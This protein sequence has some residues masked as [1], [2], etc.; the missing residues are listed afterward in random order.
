V[1]QSSR[2]QASKEKKLEKRITQEHTV[3]VRDAE[4]EKKKTYSCQADAKRAL[5]EWQKN[6]KG[7]H[8]F[9]AHIVEESMIPKRP[10]RGRPKKNELKPDPIPVYRNIIQ[11][12]PPSEETL[13]ELRRKESTFI[14][15]TSIRDDARL[16][17]EEVLRAYKEQYQV[18]QRFRFL[19]SPY[20]VGPIYLHN[21]KRVK[22]FGYVM[23]MAV[24][25]YSVLERLIRKAMEKETEPLILP[26]KRKSFAP[27]ALSILE[28]LETILVM[29]VQMQGQSLRVLPDH[30]EKQLDRILTLLEFDQGIYTKIG[31]IS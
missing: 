9:E 18:E 7:M 31:T 24:L 17:D 29:K 20:L 2:L 10:Q 30:T 26:G 11:I 28:L 6:H 5:E 22:A 21:K 8:R 12:L 27:T 3:W 14:L 16:A 13:E 15:I 1:V 23:M 19:K 4:N 25:L